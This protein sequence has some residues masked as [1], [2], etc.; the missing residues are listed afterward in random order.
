MTITKEN[1]QA[2]E[3]K[4]GHPPSTAEILA[5]G[6]KRSPVANAQPKKPIFRV[7]IWRADQP[8]LKTS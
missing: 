6:K 2:L 3:R 5:T 1:Y 8:K 7:M 4:L